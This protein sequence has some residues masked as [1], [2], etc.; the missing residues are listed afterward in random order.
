MGYKPK[1]WIKESQ[2]APFFIL[3]RGIYRNLNVS[4][5]GY[6]VSKQDDVRLDNKVETYTVKIG[7]VTKGK[8]VA[9]NTIYDVACLEGINITQEEI[10]SGNCVVMLVF[11]DTNP[12]N[13]Y[14][15]IHGANERV[16]DK[17]AT[18]ENVEDILH[19]Y[20]NAVIVGKLKVN[21]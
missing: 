13:F 12:T 4:S 7:P 20:R 1:D 15:M 16:D 11:L 18:D 9:M 2:E 14:K 3:E 10:N 21:R 17:L 19:D 8:D 5:L 6:V